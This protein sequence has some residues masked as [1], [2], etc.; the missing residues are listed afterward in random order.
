MGVTI[1]HCLF[2]LSIKW[3]PVLLVDTVEEEEENSLM[4]LSS[5]SIHVQ[6]LNGLATALKR[7]SLGVLQIYLNC[8]LFRFGAQVIVDMTSMSHSSCSTNK[9][10]IKG[11]CDVLLDLPVSK[12]QFPLF[13]L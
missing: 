8:Q 13:I 4:P 9:T 2:C 10:T 11:V 7:V 5:P 1:S 3:V 6:L 12:Q